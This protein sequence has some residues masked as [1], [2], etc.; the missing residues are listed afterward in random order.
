LGGSE[1]PKKKG[2]MPPR[3]MLGF[4]EIARRLET[5]MGIRDNK[6]HSAQPLAAQL[7]QKI[8]PEGLGFRG[9]HGHAQH[10]AAALRIDAGG[11]GDRHGDDPAILA[12]FHVSY[13]EPD[14][15]PIAFQR[16]MEKGADFAIS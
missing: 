6:L 3:R 4:T 2:A 13:V 9:T 10:F 1:S 5:L 8:S 7:G 12:H 11:D 16:T 15:G 14:I